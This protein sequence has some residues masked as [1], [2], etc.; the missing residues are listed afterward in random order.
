MR[1]SLSR[2][3]DV[4]ES[5][6]EAYSG[7]DANVLKL[8]GITREVRIPIASLC[9]SSC[10]TMSEKPVALSRRTRLAV[11]CPAVQFVARVDWGFYG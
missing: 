4:S 10:G 7:N 2:D 6:S 8:I 3:M 1:H 9:W 5:L 11:H